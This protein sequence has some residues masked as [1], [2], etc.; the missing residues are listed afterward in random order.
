MAVVK[1]GEKCGVIDKDG[2]FIINPQFD[3]MNSDGKLFKVNQDGKWGWCDDEGKFIINAQFESARN[4]G[5]SDFSA[6]KSGKEFGY[7][8]REGKFVINPQFKEALPFV[9]GMAAI[10]NGNG[11]V[12]FID[13]KGKIIINPQFNRIGEDYVYYANGNITSFYSVET[14]LFDLSVLSTRINLES[15][16]GLTTSSTMGDAAIKFGKSTNDF[17]LYSTEHRMLS[18]SRLNRNINIDFYVIGDPSKDDVISTGYYQYT[19]K[20][21]NSNAQITGFAY[22]FNLTGKGY[23]MGKSVLDVV[24]KIVENSG[25]TKDTAASSSNDYSGNSLFKKGSKQVYTKWEN[26]SIILVISAQPINAPAEATA[27]TTKAP[28]W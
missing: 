13:E 21:F 28:S 3:A 19:Q 2:K 27:D 16:E 18:E 8:D 25:Y 10:E 9:N 4:F 24:D 23:G 26:N 6:V 11:E 12:G 22:R 14:D 5:K 7:I 17:S 20:V 1:S 15:P